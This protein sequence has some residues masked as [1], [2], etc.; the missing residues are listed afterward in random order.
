MKLHDSPATIHIWADLNLY[1]DVRPA[2]VGE[3]QVAVR[4]VGYC[5]SVLA[6][7]TMTCRA[8]LRQPRMAVYD[9]LGYWMSVPNPEAA[10]SRFPALLGISPMVV[11]NTHID[12]KEVE[13][14][15][16]EPVYHVSTSVE[17]PAVRLED[18]VERTTSLQARR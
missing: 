16:G 1:R 2:V 17:L 7:E 12:T 14:I 15:T 6:W 11:V 9:S 18:F 5:R 4:D 3:D 13:V 8:A 10:E